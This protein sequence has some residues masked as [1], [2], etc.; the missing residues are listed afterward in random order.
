ML[1]PEP[2]R[3]SAAL[4]RETCPERITSGE[5]EVFEPPVAA[6]QLFH[7]D[8]HHETKRSFLVVCHHRPS[9]R[10]VGYV[11][12]NGF[13]AHGMILPG[14]ATIWFQG[15]LESMERVLA[16]FKHEEEGQ[17]PDQRRSQEDRVCLLLILLTIL[18]I[19]GLAGTMAIFAF[20]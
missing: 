1:P 5:I 16:L 14:I 8:Y 10:H 12:L 11:D 17:H 18:A 19:L 15:D 6:A 3:L 20:T 2:F 4:L 7:D 9:R 13:V